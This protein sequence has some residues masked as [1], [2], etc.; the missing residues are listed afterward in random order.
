MNTIT[1]QILDDVKSLPDQ[2]RKKLYHQTGGARLS[3][4]QGGRQQKFPK[5]V[6]VRCNLSYL[7][8]YH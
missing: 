8:I 2:C 5:T 3:S 6:R 4:S 1:K 7:V